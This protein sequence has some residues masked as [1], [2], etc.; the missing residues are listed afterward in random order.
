[1][2]IELAKQSTVDDGVLPL[3]CAR[4]TAKRAGFELT[5]ILIYLFGDHYLL[6]AM[7]QALGFARERPNSDGRKVQRWNCP[8]SSITSGLPSS[9]S[10]TICMRT[11]ITVSLL[12]QPPRRI[13]C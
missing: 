7:Q 2:E 13:V 5:E 1:V 10:K 9:A 3:P 12:V 4:R 6:H 11:F 8:T